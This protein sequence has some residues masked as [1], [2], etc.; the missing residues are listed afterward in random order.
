MRVVVQRVKQASVSV[1]G[2][3]VGAIGHGLMIPVG[4]R[5]GDTE[6]EAQ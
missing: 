5:T 2:R 3:V 4:I 1:E 6:A